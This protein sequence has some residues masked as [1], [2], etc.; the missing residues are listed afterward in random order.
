ML[1]FVHHMWW[2][3]WVSREFVLRFRLRSCIV[4][5]FNIF[6]YTRQTTRRSLLM[7][8]RLLQCLFL[9]LAG[10]IIQSHARMSERHTERDLIELSE[11]IK[12]DWGDFES[13]ECASWLMLRQRREIQC[14]LVVDSFDVILYWENIFQSQSPQSEV[15][16]VC[17]KVQ[18]IF[19]V[20]PPI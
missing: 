1:F 16:K 18:Q 19:H 6:T 11:L 5:N 3:W 9:L 10:L 17:L 13:V 4:S 12:V 8:A 15:I 2:W 14:G 7:Y 20:I